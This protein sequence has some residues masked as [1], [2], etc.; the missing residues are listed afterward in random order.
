[1]KRP[2]RQLTQKRHP[3]ASGDWFSLALIILLCLLGVMMI[4]NASHIEALIQFGDKFRYA[5]LQ[6]VWLIVSS[7][8]L[9]IS[10]RLPLTFIKRL[11]PFVMAGVTLLLVAVLIPGIGSQFQGARRWLSLGN[12][13]IQPS[14]LVKLA[15]VIYLPSILVFR[16]RLK[17]YL[18]VSVTCI[19]LVVI[20]PDF[21]TALILTGIAFSLLYLSGASK[22]IMLS[23]M[24]GAALFGSVLIASTPYRLSRVKTFLNPTH[25]PHG[26]SYHVR[27][28]LISLGSGGLSGT[29]IGRSRQKFQYLPEATTDSIF[30]VI[31]EETGFLGAASLIGL[32]V[33]L[34]LRMITRSSQLKG[35]Y[36]R[37]LASGVSLWFTLQVIV[38][39][40]AM[41][42][43][44]PLTGV[45][46]PFISYGGSALLSA[47]LGA[48]LYFNA[49][50][51]KFTLKPMR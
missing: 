47:L 45:P 23:L 40:S 21:G 2:L 36:E 32:Y 28:I 15:F 49:T 1:M 22:K 7:L 9:L 5:K 42:S 18:L 11:S 50:K 38:N 14:E 44:I 20:E 37:L 43:I 17:A 35:D 51:P 30:A 46:L 6:L 12:I 34:S 33:L 48:G 10:L 29:G 31:A 3:P 13:V 19:F 4:F 41:V 25:D 24:L 39:L 26:T 16:N 8:A 27:Q